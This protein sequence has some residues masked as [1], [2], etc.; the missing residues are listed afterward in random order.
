MT[1]TLTLVLSELHSS[2]LSSLSFLGDDAFQLAS[3]ELT[4]ELTQ[5]YVERVWWL[6]I[7]RDSLRK[8]HYA[9]GMRLKDILPLSLLRELQ[10]D[11][12][13]EI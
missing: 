8:T 2:Q 5:G 10:L 4:Q 9:Q 3:N 13:S 7:E 11:Y 1:F 6:L 12:Q